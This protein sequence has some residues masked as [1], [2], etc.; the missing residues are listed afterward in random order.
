MEVVSS[1][2]RDALVLENLA[3][4]EENQCHFISSIIGVC[5]LRKFYHSYFFVLWIDDSPLLKNVLLQK[6]Q[7]K[8][9]ILQGKLQCTS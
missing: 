9:T 2:S 3:T 6:I 7:D 5:T 1:Y 4:W 8:L